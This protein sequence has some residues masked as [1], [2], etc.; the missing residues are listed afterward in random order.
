MM[1]VHVDDGLWTGNDNMD[2]F[3]KKFCAVF[4]AKFDHNLTSILG[5]QS[6]QDAANFRLLVDLAG[7]T[8]R[9]LVRFSMDNCKPCDTPIKPKSKWRKWT[10]PPIKER[11]KEAIGALNFLTTW[12]RF[13]VSTAVNRVSRHTANPGPDDWVAVQ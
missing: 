2:E 12:V 5:M 10:G 13:D 7:Y 1:P 4:K 6:R 8:E 3:E 9:L 11:Y